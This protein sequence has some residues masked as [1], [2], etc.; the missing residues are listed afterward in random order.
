VKTSEVPVSFEAPKKKVVSNMSKKELGK[1]EKEI[2]K[3]EEQVRVIEQQLLVEQGGYSVLAE[4][5]AKRDAL[6]ETL[7]AKEES[8]LSLSEA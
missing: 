5:T 7:A 3:L 1:L 2:A 8:W 6:V 4:L